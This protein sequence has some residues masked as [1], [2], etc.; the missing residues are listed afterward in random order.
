M[1]AISWPKEEKEEEDVGLK[2]L[3][4]EKHHLN[5]VS[6]FCFDILLVFK[7]R[8]GTESSKSTHFS[9]SC[10]SLKFMA[11]GLRAPEFK[12]LGV[13]SELLIVASGN[14]KM[15]DFSMNKPENDFFWDKPQSLF[16]L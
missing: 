6:H 10:Q 16:I 7:S 1:L 13:S 12:I 9:V 2:S 5:F 11:Y 14:S 8:I 3:R 4:D 15:P